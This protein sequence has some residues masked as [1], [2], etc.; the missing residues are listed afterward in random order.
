MRPARRP[1]LL[2]ALPF[3]AAGCHHGGTVVSSRDAAQIGAAPVGEFLFDADPDAAARALP[4]SVSHEHEHAADYA[5]LRRSIDQTCGTITR[6]TPARADLRD[7]RTLELFYDLLADHPCQL[8]A[9]FDVSK[10]PYALTG[11]FLRVEPY[12]GGKELHDL[13]PVER[14]ASAPSTIAPPA[15]DA[16]ALETANGFVAALLVKP[17]AAKAS[18][19][20]S[21]AAR[22]KL[23]ADSV[24]KF[25]GTASST[26]GELKHVRPVRYLRLA[27]GSTFVYSIE[28][29]QS[30]GSLTVLVETSGTTVAV[31]E[32]SG[33]ELTPALQP[34]ADLPPAQAVDVVAR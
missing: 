1:L 24:A 13:P 29:A 4:D 22:A 8:R 27:H 32:V 26:Y 23:D 2:L 11:L 14:P 31:A 19:L 33:S 30:K 21:P 17:D 9:S 20:L 25:A 18:A 6:A 5:D 34:G 7:A 3:V 16:K 10:S 28:G 15:P 12:P